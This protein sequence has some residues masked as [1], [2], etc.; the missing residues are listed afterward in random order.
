M[1]A[2]VE[3]GVAAMVDLA[4][5]ISP[6]PVLRS[7]VYLRFP[8]HDGDG[9]RPELLRLAVQ[10]V[11]ALIRDRTPTLVFCAAGMSRSPAVTAHAMALAEGRNPK[12]CLRQIVAGR[13]HD[14]SP[15]LWQA[16]ERL[17][18]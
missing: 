13:P 2:V 10:T 17:F 12:E 8:I 15:V 11:T 14:V 5:E 7:M 18:S 1:V 4:T 3:A 9:N 6:P 16:L